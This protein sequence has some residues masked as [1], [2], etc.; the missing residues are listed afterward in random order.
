M[1][2]QVSPNLVNQTTFARADVVE[3]FQSLDALFEP[4]KVIFEKLLPAIR[5]KRILDLGIGAGRTTKYLLQISRDY[6]GIDYI[7]E[8]ARETG[9]QYPDAKILCGDARDLKEFEDES[10]DFVLFSFNGLDCISGEDRL[11]AL[12]EIYRVL[13]KGGFFMFS[14]HNRDYQHFKKLPWQRK[15]Q[16]DLNYFKFFLYCL[17]HLPAH[18]R[19]KKHEIYT[20]DYA[21]INDPDHRFSLLLYYI[22]I[23][24]QVKQLANVGFSDVEA[25]DQQGKLV[26]SDTSSHWIYYL[27]KK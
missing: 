1:Y 6:T 3:Y 7:P 17:Y 21:L 10:F 20:D 25:Y 4:E 24:K 19:M 16:Y 23:E 9:R 2:V 5:N 14:S 11:K 18:S 8:F 27:A 13:K 12:E 26:E 15:I 22:S